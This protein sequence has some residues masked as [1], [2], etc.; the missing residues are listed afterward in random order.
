MSAGDFG[1][2]LGVSSQTIYNWEHG[3]ARPRPLL[4]EK[5]ATLRGLG[6]REAIAYVRALDGRG[7]KNS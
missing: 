5:L 4:L 3:T 7:V 1:K 2:L 6:K